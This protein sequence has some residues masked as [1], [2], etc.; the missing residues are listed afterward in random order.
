MKTDS[1]KVYKGFIYRKSTLLVPY[2]KLSQGKAVKCMK[3]LYEFQVMGSDGKP[4]WRK[5]DAYNE[6]EVKLFLNDLAN[7]ESPVYF[8]IRHMKAV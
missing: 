3:N 4:H 8:P 2:F 6:K 5:I 7:G 1:P